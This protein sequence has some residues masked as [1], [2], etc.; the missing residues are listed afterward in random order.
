MTD[1]VELVVELRRAVRGF[2]VEPEILRQWRGALRDEE[3]SSAQTHPVR[4][5]SRDESSNVLGC[6][7]GRIFVGTYVPP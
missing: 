6:F 2:D 5:M 7:G 3:T 4:G 1:R